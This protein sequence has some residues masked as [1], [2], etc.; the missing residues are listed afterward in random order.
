[1]VQSDTG[2]TSS[3]GHNILG[4]TIDGEVVNVPDHHGRLDWTDICMHA[5]KVV[6]FID[7]AGHEKYLKTTVFGLTGHMPDYVLLVVGANAGLVGMCKEHL[8]LALALNVPVIV[9]VTKVDMC[10]PNILKVRTLFVLS[11]SLSCWAELG[12]LPF[13]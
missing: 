6:T 5:S 3:I 2:R 8:G 11:L 4:L 10:P 7:L 12:R 1:V 9:V 13:F